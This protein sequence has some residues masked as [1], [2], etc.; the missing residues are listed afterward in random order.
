MKKKQSTWPDGLSDLFEHVSSIPANDEIELRVAVHD[1]Q[2]YVSQSLGKHQNIDDAI[3][4][5]CSDIVRQATQNIPL[6]ISEKH[7]GQHHDKPYIRS[8]NALIR[9][10]LP[11]LEEPQQDLCMDGL[12]LQKC[13]LDHINL[14]GSSFR[15]ADLSYCKLSR[16]DLKRVDFRFANLMGAIL[17]H[18]KLSES[19]MESCEMD[20]CDLSYADLYH[21][22]LMQ[23]DLGGSI[24]EHADLSYA[25]LSSAN[26][27]NATLNHANLSHANLFGARLHSAK[28]HGCDLT[29]TGITPERLEH[30]GMKTYADQGTIWGSDNDCCGRNPFDPAYY[31]EQQNLL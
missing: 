18:A 6:P 3:L 9:T 14:N 25:I 4:A 12:N 28:L 11:R 2:S 15:M 31:T 17:T 21:S 13:E 7:L 27:A 22:Q 16:T 26:L 5:S 19:L 24:L 30:A 23:A 20:W 10:L 29:G 8:V 1:L